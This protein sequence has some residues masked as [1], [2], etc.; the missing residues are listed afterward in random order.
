MR[1]HYHKNSRKN[2]G[3]HA[4]IYAIVL[5][6]EG[7]VGI[8][9]TRTESKS[10]MLSLHHAPL[11][12]AIYRNRTCFFGFSVRRNNHTCSDC[13]VPSD[14]IELPNPSCKGGVIPFNYEGYIALSLFPFLNP[15]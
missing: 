4:T 3:F 9:P 14:R 8:K 7:A 1:K 10:V 12:G 5:V 13:L 2:S 11:D 6:L 15:T